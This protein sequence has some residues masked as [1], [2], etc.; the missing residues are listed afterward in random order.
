MLAT[1]RLLG[2]VS[3]VVGI[4]LITHIFFFGR[5]ASK[6]MHYPPPR[7]LDGDQ[8][9]KEKPFLPLVP[10]IRTGDYIRAS[11]PLMSKLASLATPV[12]NCNPVISPKNP[13]ATPVFENGAALCIRPIKSLIAYFTLSPQNILR[14]SL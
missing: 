12:L 6:Q 13:V 5:P 4:I 2:P 3:F 14:S 10:Q 1:G 7:E 9:H 8:H 11:Y